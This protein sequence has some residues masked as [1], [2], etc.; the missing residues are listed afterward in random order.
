MFLVSLAISKHPAMLLGHSQTSRGDHP[1]AGCVQS[2]G[3]SGI[4]STGNTT[5]KSTQLENPESGGLVEERRGAD[6][7]FSRKFQKI[8]EVFL[9]S[10]SRSI[11]P[12]GIFIT[13]TSRRQDQ[14]K[15]PAI[16]RRLL[17]ACYDLFGVQ[18][19]GFF[20]SFSGSCLEVIYFFARRNLN[21]YFSY[22][23]LQ[24]LQHSEQQT[25]NRAFDLTQKQTKKQ[26]S[27]ARWPRKTGASAALMILESLANTETRQTFFY[28]QTL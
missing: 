14:I 18:M 9:P 1:F 28:D 3:A 24:P 27:L 22:F 26:C 19:S 7:W 6:K 12:V 10:A 15:L 8:H 5:R 20:S 13:S 21:V 25:A 17:F 11:S 23:P 2:E 4:S 16:F